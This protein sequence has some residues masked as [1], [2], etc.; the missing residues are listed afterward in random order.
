MSNIEQALVAAA[1]AFLQ[2][3][4]SAAQPPAAPPSYP[5]PAAPVAPPPPPAPVAPPQANTYAPPGTMPG[6]P[7]S[8]PPAP[9]PQGLPFTNNIEAQNWTTAAWN[10]AVAVN[11]DQAQAE[12]GA[13]MGQ[14]G[15]ADFNHIGPEKF[16]I[17]YN[18]VMAI[19]AK[20][21]IQG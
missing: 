1:S 14:L 2:A 9:A 20:M 17:L 4:S 18:G 21:G 16:P 15:T 11:Q 12:F 5:P 7:Y 19:K 13:L 8:Q 10:A 6:A 3:M